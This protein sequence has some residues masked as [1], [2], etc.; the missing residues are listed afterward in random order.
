MALD[1]QAR[2]YQ[3]HRSVGRVMD[4]IGSMNQGS[5]NQVLRLV[6]TLSGVKRKRTSH[7]KVRRVTVDLPDRGSSSFT[8]KRK[9]RRKKK[10]SKKGAYR[11]SKAVK[12]YV[13]N[14]PTKGRKLISVIKSSGTLATLANQCSYNDSVNDV[15]SERALRI[16]NRTALLQ[17]CDDEYKELFTSA[18]STTNL[19]LAQANSILEYHQTGVLD[20]VNNYHYPVQC[21][22]YCVKNKKTNPSTLNPDLAVKEGL[23]DQKI[24]TP[25]TNIC[26]YARHSPV[27]R[28]MYKVL[29]TETFVLQPGE[30]SKHRIST[31]RRR[32]N[33][34]YLQDQLESA[35]NLFEN[36]ANRTYHILVRLQGSIGHGVT[37]NVDTDDVGYLPAK[38]DCVF[39]VKSV[40]RFIGGRQIQEFK[41]EISDLNQAMVLV[42]K[43]DPGEEKEL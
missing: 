13:D 37:E 17:L 2:S 33:I 40:T 27:F 15:D 42:N 24:P 14:A 19:T 35:E 4:L 5:V 26:Y 10:K 36:I 9:R 11:V 25:E 18:Q 16:G 1:E 41:S 7:G 39:T 38:V 22:V 12:R 31:G 43:E 34:R 3:L 28:E 6:Q 32:I 30:H 21:T 20:M 8:M 29:S 23:G